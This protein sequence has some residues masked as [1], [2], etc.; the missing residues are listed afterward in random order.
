M[1]IQRICTGI[2]MKGL[3][4]IHDPWED[5]VLVKYEDLKKGIL[6]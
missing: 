3:G 6:A 4:Q 5:S 1:A 2:G